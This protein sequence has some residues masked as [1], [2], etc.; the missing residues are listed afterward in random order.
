MIQ[1]MIQLQFKL[2]STKPNSLN[3]SYPIMD[4]Y[5]NIKKRVLISKNI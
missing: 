1:N 5:S 4:L 2:I 3:F